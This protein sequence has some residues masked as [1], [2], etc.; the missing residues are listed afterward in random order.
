MSNCKYNFCKSIL[1]KVPGKMFAKVLQ[2][3]NKIKLFILLSLTLN[4]SWS[5]KFL[6]VTQLMEESLLPT[7]MPQQ[8]NAIFANQQYLFNGL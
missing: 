1:V 5:L 4:S 2:K 6:P 8:L 3:K 7:F